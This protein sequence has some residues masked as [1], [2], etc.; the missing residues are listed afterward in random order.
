MFYLRFAWFLRKWL[1]VLI[2]M[3]KLFS[4]TKIFLFIIVSEVVE[5]NE[6]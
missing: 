2:S 3:I 4:F 5:K 1:D 6:R